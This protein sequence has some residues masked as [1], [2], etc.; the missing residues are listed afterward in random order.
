MRLSDAIEEFIKTMMEQEEAEIEL[1][2]ND[3]AQYFGCAPS[4]INYVLS[5]R[6]TPDHGYV[7]ESRRGGGGCIRIIRIERESGEFLQ[8]L[9][10]ERI[11]DAISPRAAQILCSK[12][13]EQG[14][15]SQRTAQVMCAA[16]APESFSVPIPEAL[17][18]R[19]RAKMLRNMLTT[20]ARHRAT[21]G[22]G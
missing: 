19:L 8:F 13:A 14:A 16:M 10:E 6:F 18:D 4:Q 17:K 22:E 3:L 1:K 5:T 11:G 21:S 7:T 12:L 2:R 15:I 9:L 20:V